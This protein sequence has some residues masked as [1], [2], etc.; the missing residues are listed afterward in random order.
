MIRRPPRST[1]SRSSAAS[2]VY[3]RQEIAASLI[4]SIYKYKAVGMAAPQIGILK[5]IFVNH[6]YLNLIFS[7]SIIAIFFEVI[8]LYIFPK[9]VS[10][11]KFK[12]KTNLFKNLFL[13]K[14]KLK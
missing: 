12:I 14:S 1:Q 6:G 8:C 7:F 2:D 4:V 5:N 9:F 3:K 13:N 10:D 11:Q